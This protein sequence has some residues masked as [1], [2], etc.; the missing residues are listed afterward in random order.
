MERHYHH[1]QQPTGVAGMSSQVTTTPNPIAT[2]VATTQVPAQ[3][4]LGESVNILQMGELAAAL[5]SIVALVMILRNWL[6]SSVD[7]L[8]KKVDNQRSMQDQRIVVIEK[9]IDKLEDDREG[10][11][12]RLT[13]LENNYRHIKETTDEIK[14]MVTN[15]MHSLTSRK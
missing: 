10:H 1:H 6:K 7:T 13:M 15:I 12:I 8:E 9:A 4:Q 14:L 2:T 5:L 3:L 11:S